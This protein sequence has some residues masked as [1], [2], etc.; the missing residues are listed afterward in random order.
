MKQ[1]GFLCDF[2]QRP[3]LGVWT[4]SPEEAQNSV[5][6]GATMPRITATEAAEPPTPVETR[7]SL[8]MVGA[9][10]LSIV[11]IHKLLNQQEARNDRN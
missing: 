2:Y 3:G 1:S 6:P 4:S 10:L 5:A 7:N 8:L 11:L 9:G